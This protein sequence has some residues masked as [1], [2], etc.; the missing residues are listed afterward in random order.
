MTLLDQT[1]LPVREVYTECRDAQAISDAVKRLIVRGAPAIGVAGAYGMVAAA[2]WVPNGADFMTGL[3]AA[4][5]YLNSAR[6]TA[7]NLSWATTRVLKRAQRTISGDC[8]EIR[9]VML[10]EAQAIHAEDRSL[11]QS[12]GE[13]AVD[14]IS[15]CR[16]VLTHCN[17]GA[18]ATTGIGTATA[19]MYLA[20]SM[21]HEFCVYCDETRP[22]LQ[23]SRLTAWELSRAGIEAVVLADGAAGSLLREGKVQLVITGADRIA[24]NGDAANKIGTYSL[25]V[26]ARRHGVPFYIA[27]PYSTFDLSIADGSAIPIEH[28]SA[29]ELRQILG[30]PT[31]PKDIRAYNPAFD[32]TPAEL[33]T[34]II[35]DRGIIS[36]VR[37]EQIKRVLAQEG[38][39]RE[40]CQE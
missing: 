15:R 22:L 2:Q 6:P 12:I 26:L 13:H 30:Q 36:P 8:D 28:R 10:E 17:A 3:E 23:G 9:K 21:G 19:G 34:A 29:Q 14:L 31:A 16:G 4:A 32:V 18:L 11:C 27:A 37:P 20:R 24:V 39:A 40:R 1:Q 38:P 5:E 35:T 7:V 25:A 33:I